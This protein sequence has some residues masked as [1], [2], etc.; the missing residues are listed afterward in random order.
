MFIEIKVHGSADI[1]EH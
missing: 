1:N